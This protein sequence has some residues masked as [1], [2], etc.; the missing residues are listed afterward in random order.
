[1]KTYEQLVSDALTRIE[2]CFPW[3]LADRLTEG[4]SETLLI[5]IREPYEYAAMHIKGALN[6]PR[7][8]LESACE[9]GY[10]ETVPEL[11][12]ARQREVVLICR[13]GKRSALAADV[14]RQLGYEKV[15]S[16]KTGMRGWSDY[17]QEMVDAD[18]VVVDEERAIDYFTPRLKPEQQGHTP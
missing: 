2:E 9:Y 7:G 12:A 4:A 6:V 11:A 5:D 16:L 13:S 3:D 1:M 17:E 10:E 18:G 14:L 8:V 15:V